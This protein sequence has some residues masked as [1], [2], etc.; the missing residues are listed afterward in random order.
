[1]D[2]KK[3]NKKP[4]LVSRYKFTQIKRLTKKEK[5]ALEAK[6]HAEAVKRN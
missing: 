2:K 1:M 3:K 6:R 5:K 4:E